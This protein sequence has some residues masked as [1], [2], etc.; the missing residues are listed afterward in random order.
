M[1]IIKNISSKDLLSVINFINCEIKDFNKF[2]KLGWNYKNIENHFKKNNNFSIGYFDRNKIYGIL[3]GEKIKQSTKFD[4]EVHIMFVNK[5]IRRNN[6][7][8]NMLNYVE[9]NKKFNNISK[10]YLE[11]S[12][13]NT[14]A[15]KFYEKNNFVFLNFRHNYYKYNGKI[16]NAKCYSKII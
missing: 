8:S 7:G 10:I 1:K 4:L 5:N 16:V 13:D 11:V 9:S 6:V 14:Y 3:I 2:S 12:E 15:I